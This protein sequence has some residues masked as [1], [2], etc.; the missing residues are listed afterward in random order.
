[1]YQASLRPSQRNL[2]ML[3]PRKRSLK[4]V[5]QRII[6]SEY[7]ECKAFWDYICRKGMQEDWIK[8]A[9]ERIG[10]PPWYVKSLIRI[11][12]R[13]GLPDYQ[14]IVSNDK[15]HSLFL[16]I[17]RVDQRSLKKRAEQAGIIDRL[18]E[19]NHFAC[20]VYGVEDAI[21]IVERYLKNEL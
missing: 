21:S 18:L 5:G 10:D 7:E 6:P 8:H 20:F 15:Y 11:G 13:K 1:M 12:L 3:R 9:N 17:K 19:R 2:T 14:Y 4:L 16:E